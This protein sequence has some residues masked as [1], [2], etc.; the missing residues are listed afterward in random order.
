MTNSQVKDFRFGTQS[1]EDQG[2]ATAHVED[3]HQGGGVL[4]HVASKN[5]GDIQASSLKLGKD[6]HVCRLEKTSCMILGNILL[7]IFFC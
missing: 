5:A 2:S 7:M 4:L 6:R 3:I 1:N